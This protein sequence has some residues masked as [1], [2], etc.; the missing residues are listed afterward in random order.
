MA[1]FRFKSRVAEKTKTEAKEAKAMH[2]FKKLKQKNNI[3][4]LHTLNKTS[5][6]DPTTASNSGIIT[7]QGNVLIGNRS[8]SKKNLIIFA[9]VFAV[10]GTSIVFRSFAATAPLANIWVDTNGGSCTRSTTATAYDDAAACSLTQALTKALASD[11]VFLKNGSYPQTGL[12]FPK[13]ATSEAQRITISSAPGETATITGSPFEIS[14]GE[15]FITLTNLKFDQRT[16]AR[17]SISIQIFAN[18]ITLKNN[19]ITNNHMQGSCITLSNYEGSP[20]PI[21]Y[22]VVIEGNKIHD[23]GYIDS[24]NTEHDHGIYVANSD[25]AKIV[26][27][28]I[29]ANGGGW[30]IQLYTSSRNSLIEHNV[31]DG[32]GD[33][34]GT[35]SG[36]GYGGNMILASG[37]GLPPSSGNTIKNN[38]FANPRK[39]SGSYNIELYWGG[40]TGTSNNVSNNCMYGA[41]S[42]NIG[43][44]T[45]GFTESGTVTADPQYR[46]YDKNHAD[47]LKLNTTSPCLAIPGFYDTAAK[48]AGAA[49]PPVACADGQDN[50]SDTKTDYP[51]D[52]GCTSAADTDETDA[53]P[54][55]PP[56]PTT[57]AIHVAPSGSDT[58]GDGSTAKPYATIQKAADV[59]N[60]GG[61]VI[62]KDGVYTDTNADKTVVKLTRG[63]SSSTNLVTFKSENKWGAKIDGQS[64]TKRYGFEFGSG[65]GFVKIEGFDIYGFGDSGDYGIAAAAASGIFMKDGGGDSYIV[66]NNIHNISNFCNPTIR[67]QAGV[68]IQKNGVT[69]EG[70]VFTTIGRYDPG[71]NGCSYPSGFNKHTN[72]DTAIYA[73]SPGNSNITI[74][75]NLFYKLENGRSVYVYQGGSSNMRILNNTFAYGNPYCGYSQI[76][77]DADMVNLEI[78]NNVFYNTA[79][80]YMWAWDEETLTNVTVSNNIST[81]NFM[82]TGA[83]CS[84][85]VAT[86]PG[87]TE[88]NNQFNTNPQLVDPNAPLTGGFKLKSTSPAINAGASLADVPLDIDG[89]GRPQSSAYDAGAY[90]FTGTPPP[91]SDTTPPTVS[92]TTPANNATVVGT[93]DITATATDTVPGTVSSVQFQLDGA[94]RGSEDPV[95]PYSLSIDTLTLTNGSHTVTAVARDTAGLTTEANIVT[96][97]VQNP[98]TKPPKPPLNLCGPTSPLTA[99]GA[100]TLT[101][102]AAIDTADQQGPNGSGIKHY[103]VQRNGATIAT[104]PAASTVPAITCNGSPANYSYTDSAVPASTTPYSYVVLSVDNASPTGL[105]SIASPAYNVTVN[106]PPPPPPTNTFQIPPTATA[107]QVSS[108]QLNIA[109]SGAADPDGIAGYNLYRSTSQ[110]GPFTTKVNTSLLTAVGSC[111][112]STSCSLGD[113]GLTPGTTYYYRVEAIDNMG[114]LGNSN[115]TSAATKSLITLPTINPTAD[116]WIN[117]SS[118]SRTYG[119]TTTM[120]SD[121]S[122]NQDAIMNFTVSGIGTKKVTSAKLRLYVANGSPSAGEIYR[123]LTASWNE[124]SVNWNTVP[125]HNPIALKT[126]GIASTGT[127]LEI[128]LTSVVTADGVYGFKLSTPSS[129]NAV[130]NTREAS[131]NKPQLILK[132]E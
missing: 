117:Q 62:V 10:L 35:H 59:V 39:I 5:P 106:D 94:N 69:L 89:I 90:E 71:E 88:I 120:K 112:G 74:K 45:G 132:V 21:V 129:N 37:S 29:Y 119:T 92:I 109:W 15:N 6:A 42:S 51:A 7:S 30:G 31:L 96:I 34:T 8:I 32:N 66:G 67:P 113:T 33:L 18:G 23:C 58:T 24:T 73:Q 63:G 84:S 17:T 108:T 1:H 114:K 11:T 28:L 60:A 110:A 130:Y 53:A 61:T 85:G 12:D 64:N 78:K 115:I 36:Y 127:Y 22:D 76:F 77:T 122:P 131:A 87:V 82:M 41:I 2:L 86:Q 128:D 111:N 9:I 83:N 25:R 95:S 50:D 65:I 105:T 57:G 13:T 16:P 47:F 99:P 4:S 40:A 97:N 56:P 43:G 100:A 49:A 54:P 118:P 101:W 125:A 79:A 80:S 70:N 102:P 126:L 52:P 107:S 75:N 48:L 3:D 19:D 116:A 98:D 26:D 46:S 104:V 44:D 55:P 20:S 14:P 121:G 27:N 81:G 124:A 93:I 103:L 38:I 72:N 91:P 123:L 68:Y